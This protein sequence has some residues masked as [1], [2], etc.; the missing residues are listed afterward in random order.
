MDT[1]WLRLCDGH[2]CNLSRSAYSFKFVGLMVRERWTG[3]KI[4]SV[5]GHS[6]WWSTREC[7]SEPEFQDFVLHDF[8]IFPCVVLCIPGS[9][10]PMI[11]SRSDMV[12]NH[13]CK[14]IHV[15]Y[16]QKVGTQKNKSY[17]FKSNTFHTLRYRFFLGQDVVIKFIPIPTTNSAKEAHTNADFM[18]WVS[19]LTSQGL[20]DSCPL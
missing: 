11:T 20:W 17:C 15:A 14:K 3:G 9:W 2:P 10:I 1:K 16:L 19:L 5:R 6:K 18:T 8:I 4:H 13:G 7:K 12:E